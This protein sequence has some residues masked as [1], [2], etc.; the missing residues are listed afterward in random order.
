M[1]TFSQDFSFSSPSTADVLALAMLCAHSLLVEKAGT[2]ERVQT[3]HPATAGRR[4]PMPGLI[5]TDLRSRGV[6]VQSMN[7]PGFKAFDRAAPSVKLLTPHSAKGLEFPLVVIL[8]LDALPLRDEPMDDE[9]RL[10]SVGMTRAPHELLMSAAANSP[11]VQRVRNSLE[12]VTQQ[13][14]G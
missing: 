12:A 3:V 13:F 9:V 10:L 11:R 6:S 4:G 1:Y 8:G 7:A 2:D 14:A 5:Q